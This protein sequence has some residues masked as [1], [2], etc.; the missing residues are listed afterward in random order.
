[1]REALAIGCERLVTGHGA[2]DGG[3]QAHALVLRALADESMPA[4]W[5]ARLGERLTPISSA[6]TGRPLAIRKEIRES[7]RISFSVSLAT[8]GRIE[9][10]HQPPPKPGARFARNLRR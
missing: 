5:R 2:G 8:T 3:H 9:A 1:V 7:W 10:R 6:E 4:A